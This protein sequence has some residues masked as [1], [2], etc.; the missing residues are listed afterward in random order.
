MIIILKVIAQRQWCKSLFCENINALTLFTDKDSHIATEKKSH[1]HGTLLEKRPKYQ[2]PKAPESN[3]TVLLFVNKSQMPFVGSFCLG[4]C[5][6][7]CHLQVKA[8]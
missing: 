5:R 7:H 8:F 3:F 4:C 1:E 6:K 2:L